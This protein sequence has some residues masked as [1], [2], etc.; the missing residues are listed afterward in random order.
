MKLYLIKSEDISIFD[1]IKREYAPSF[2]DENNLESKNVLF[3]LDGY[4]N[5]VVNQNIVTDLLM[6]KTF[7]NSTIIIT[8]RHLQAPPLNLFTNA[9]DIVGLKQSDVKGFLTT[10]SRLQQTE[11]IFKIDLDTHP[12]GSMLTTPLYLWIYVGFGE[13]LHENVALLSR[14][15]FY[16][17]VVN[18][19]LNKAIYRLNKLHSECEDG[20]NRLRKIA[21]ECLLK[22]QYY[23]SE[24]LT[25]VEKNLGYL[26]IVPISYV[27]EN[28]E[29][30]YKFIHST[31][32]EFLG[33]QYIVKHHGSNICATLKRVVDHPLVITFICGLLTNSDQLKAVFD[34][35]VPKCRELGDNENEHDT[36]HYGLQAI[37]EIVDI[38]LRLINT[39][40][41]GK[42]QKKVTLSCSDC[43]H[44]CELGLYRMV[45]M[46]RPE[47]YTP[48]QR[49]IRFVR[50]HYYNLKKF[51]LRYSHDN[52]VNTLGQCNIMHEILKFSN[53]NVLGVSHYMSPE[54]WGYIKAYYGTCRS[55]KRSSPGLCPG[56]IYVT[57]LV[58]WTIIV[59][60][61]L[62]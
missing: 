58:N 4:D 6:R 7:R 34:M 9:F 27:K 45:T 16:K 59:N 51:T 42:V 36:N 44:F 61:Y 10:M 21:F 8:A 1:Y 55:T 52:V 20:L 2:L 30:E 57:G 17:R 33:A 25:E 62:L 18:G 3:I 47:I 19:I 24:D 13:H 23:F 46:S 56:R 43:S 26:K 37:A 15:L 31:F 48:I 53:C 41:I 60:N 39:A 22:G 54:V 32:L 35:F 49:V 38:D 14:T 11:S 29:T 5:L 28:Y 12:L 50:H 40:W